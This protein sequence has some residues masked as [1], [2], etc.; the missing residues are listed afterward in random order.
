MVYSVWVHAIWRSTIQD[1]LIVPVPPD[2]PVVRSAS[3]H[4]P[5]HGVVNVLA[6]VVI[7]CVMEDILVVD[8]PF[9][10]A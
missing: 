1:Q 6:V 3:V 8:V 4:V 9:V 2:T 5:V 7:N 10:P